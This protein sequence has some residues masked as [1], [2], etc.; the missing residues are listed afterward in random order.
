MPEPKIKASKGPARGAASGKD[1]L[2]RSQEI[3]ED[4]K[5]AVDPAQDEVDKVWALVE[6]CRHDTP[7]LPRDE[8]CKFCGNVCN[9]WKK[10]TVHLAKHMEQIS[11]PVLRLAEQKAVTFDTIVSP[12]EQRMLQQ[13]R[14]SSSI[15]PGPVPKVETHHA[16]P[17][18]IPENVY[19]PAGNLSAPYGMHD[20]RGYYGA[21]NAGRLQATNTYTPIPVSHFSAHTPLPTSMGNYAE[22][23]NTTFSMP[24]YQSYE[25]HP[26][27]QFAHVNAPRGFAG[28]P[29]AQGGSSFDVMRGPVP[30]TRAR[31]PSA[32]PPMPIYDPQQAFQHPMEGNPFLYHNTGGVAQP[33][34]MSVPVAIQYDPIT[35]VPYTQAPSGTPATYPQDPPNYP[36]R[37]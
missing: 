31:Y 7:K 4:W 37:Q 5:A 26:P 14:L 27:R 23:G 12:V 13:R 20:Q 28:P 9:S 29:S 22:S 2:G 10:L 15:S 1:R 8:A 33:T 16:S 18:D 11:M 34:G 17:Y 19:P 3:V 36:Y 32:G 25:E 30:T 21:P 35:G 6:K 24:S